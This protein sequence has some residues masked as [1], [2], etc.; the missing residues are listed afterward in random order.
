MGFKDDWSAVFTRIGWRNSREDCPINLK[1]IQFDYFHRTLDLEKSFPGQFPFCGACA[2]ENGDS[3]ETVLIAWSY[4]LW[5]SS[6][7]QR[8]V[9]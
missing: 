8:L 4:I 9:D 7:A 5:V 2:E 6:L 1:Y 3:N